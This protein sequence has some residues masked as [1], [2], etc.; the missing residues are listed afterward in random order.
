MSDATAPEQTDGVSADPEESPEQSPE[1]AELA[2][3]V[4][5]LAAENRRL[6]DLLAERQQSR[7]RET[8]LGLAGVGLVCGLLGYVTPA[9]STVLFALAGTGLF[10]G[11]L[12]YFLTPERFSSADVGH[13]VYAAT[14]Q[15]FS[16][17]C[18]DLGLSDRRVYL[19]AHTDDEDDEIA[20]SDVESW[21]FVPQTQD[22]EIP[23]ADAFDSAF[24]VE[25]DHRGLAVQ[26]TGSDL[27]T[28]IRDS[29]TE[30]FG[31]SPERLC[32]QLTDAIVE[33]FELAT[34]AEYDIDQADGRVSVRFTGALYGDGTQ[35][36]HPIVSVMAVGLAAGLQTA[37]ETT[38]TESDPLAV[39]FRWDLEHDD[40]N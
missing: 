4:D 11:V 6:R 9:A 27:I 18:D 30:P 14:A 22:T 23:A 38:V 5:L 3:Q 25:D 31:D 24:L 16:R 10:A 19:V 36:D 35:F 1:E 2:A 39:T 26:P 28:A 37:I 17:L 12:T 40:S 29:L 13:R 8:A 33:D 32:S 34:S 20:E 15:S 7:Y 21:L